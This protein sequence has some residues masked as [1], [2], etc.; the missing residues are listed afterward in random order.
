LSDAA[1]SG[2]STLNTQPN[3]TSE[4]ATQP[5]LTSEDATQPNLTSEDA[6]QPNLTSEDATQP[7]ASTADATTSVAALDP[8]QSDAASISDGGSGTSNT[9]GETLS[10]DL[11]QVTEALDAALGTITPHDDSSAWPT[12]DAGVSNGNST[13]DQTA[14]ADCSCRTVGRATPNT[15][16]YAFAPLILFGMAWGRRARAK[17]ARPLTSRSALGY[18]AFDSD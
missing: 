4:D 15:A 1:A 2:S 12:S 13:S 17:R 18:S 3:L 9:T 14:Q 5:N 7:R 6:T 11:A 16:L 10:I 8:T